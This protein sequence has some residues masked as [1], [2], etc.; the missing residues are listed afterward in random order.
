[1]NSVIHW[2]LNSFKQK[3]L[4]QIQ[5]QYTIVPN[6]PRKIEKTNELRGL[7]AMPTLASYLYNGTEDVSKAAAGAIQQITNSCSVAELI[8]LDRAMRYISDWGSSHFTITQ[9]FSRFHGQI[10]AIGIFASHQNGRIRE[11]ATRALALVHD[12]Q[13]LPFLFIRLND[14]VPQVRS[15]AKDAIIDRIR[16]DYI[17]HFVK[18]LPLIFRLPEQHRED[19]TQLFHNILNLL[20]SRDGHSA[21]THAL[22]SPDHHIRRLA[23]RLLLQNPSYEPTSMLLASL[24]SNDLTIRLLAGRELRH[25]L[26]DPPLLQTLEQMLIDPFMP[27]RREALYGFLERLPAASHGHFQAALL[28]PHVSIREFARFHL[29]NHEPF[30]FIEFYLDHLSTTENEILTTAIAGVGETGKPAHAATLIQF[31]NHRNALVRRASIRAIAHLDP[32]HHAE[33]LIAALQ[34][35]SVAVARIARDAIHTRPHLASPENLWSIFTSTTHQHVRGFTLDLIALAPWWNSISL[36]IRAVATGDEFVRQRVAVHLSNWEISPVR[37]LARPT[38]NQ[39]LE[40]DQLIASY[41]QSLNPSIMADLHQGIEWTKR[42][43]LN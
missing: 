25:R 10:G 8:Q 42:Q 14:W 32:E 6:D 19:H 22:T 43:M 40:L 39:L 1:M 36:F 28:D 24:H 27:I 17:A 9:L 16:P 7:S 23:F 34:D 31:L 26:N 5:P 38:P 20:H 33:Q 4:P 37:Y 18:C 41:P 2:I 21:I 35:S 12:G 15:P 29:R 30:D 11:T 13:E 3:P